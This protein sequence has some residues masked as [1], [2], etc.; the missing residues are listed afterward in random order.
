MSI[1]AL[2]VE[3]PEDASKAESIAAM[4]DEVDVRDWVFRR[5]ILDQYP[6]SFAE[7]IAKEYAR[8]HKT[9]GRRQANLFMLD[10]KDNLSSQLLK[11][12]ASDEE[13]KNYAKRKAEEMS[14]LSG[15]W[16]NPEDAVQCLCE[17]TYYRYRIFPPLISQ[18]GASSVPVTVTVPDTGE[19]VSVTVSVTGLLGRLKDEHWW[20]RNLRNYHIRKVEAKA[21][22]LGLVN[23]LKGKYV[24][25]ETMQRVRKQKR[26]NRKTL[27]HCIAV[28]ELD[29]KYTLQEL[30]DKSVSNPE[31]QHA[32]LM[33]R[34]DG[35]DIYAV[36]HG[37]VAKFYTV[38]CPSRM[39][40]TKTNRIT[41]VTSRNYKYDKTTPREAQQYQNKVWQ[42]IRAKLDRLGIKVYG[43][44]VAEPHQDGTPHWHF[45]LY[46]ASE[47][48]NIV[49]EVFRHY[50]LEDSPNEHGAHEHRVVIE[51]I[52]R[53]IG[54]G[55]SYIAKYISKGTTGKGLDSDKDGSAL[56]GAPE[57]VKAWAVTWGN[58]QFQQIGGPLVSVWREFRK[59][60]GDSLKGL[61]LKLWDA[62]NNNAWDIFTELM[63]GARARRK[64][65]PVSLAKQWND[66]PNRY[67]EPI[68][69]EVI[70]LA[71]GNVVIPTKM[72][73]WTIH[74][75][76]EVTSRPVGIL[77]LGAQAPLEFCQ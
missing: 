2:K 10:I 47:V 42:R 8:I 1:H 11:L 5:A 65:C 27:E 67:K 58:R 70:G 22:E 7:V 4:H 71:Y 34:I 45:L 51:T 73:Q 40:P 75:Q 55:T 62:V 37:H 77:Q 44:R 21:I 9:Q 66:K 6:P 49:D 36:K 53:S 57:R 20:R 16:K 60:T 30:S 63:G 17:I 3:L 50:A 38:T 64:D 25:N 69:E 14:R 31:V 24:S 18:L 15:Y 13:I 48:A 54:K 28:N 29:Q 33:T 43:F 41:E 32:E 59:I 35:F 72:H 52:N 76:P 68:G 46:M 39:H 26:R 12:A 61:A 19:S 56:D 23:K 74:Y